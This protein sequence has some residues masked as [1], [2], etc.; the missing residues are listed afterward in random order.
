MKALLNLLT[1]LAAWLNLTT[2]CGLTARR[3]AT[4]GLLQLGQTLAGN[5]L[6]GG[7]VAGNVVTGLG[8]ALVRN[9]QGRLLD[10]IGSINVGSLTSGTSSVISGSGSSVAG[11][12]GNPGLLIGQGLHNAGQAFAGGLVIA[13]SNTASSTRF[14]GSIRDNSA[15]N[16]GVSVSQHGGL[17]GGLPSGLPIGGVLPGGTLTV[18]SVPGSGGGPGPLAEGARPASGLLPGSLGLLPTGGLPGSVSSHRSVSSSSISTSAVNTIGTLGQAPQQTNQP[19]GTGPLGPGSVPINSAAGSVAQLAA[20]TTGNFLGVTANLNGGHSGSEAPNGVSGL[21]PTGS[22]PAGRATVSGLIN[23]VDSLGGTGGGPSSVGVPV[24]SNPGTGTNAGPGLGQPLQQRG[25]TLGRL[26]VGAGVATINAATA[27]AVQIAHNSGRS[28]LG[29]VPSPNG[30]GPS[31]GAPTGGIGPA[32][33]GAGTGTIPVQGLGQTLPQNSQTLG[34]VPTGAGTATIHSALSSATQITRTSMGNIQGISSTL[35]NAG[36]GVGNPTGGGR[37]DSNGAGLGIG[38]AN[39]VGLVGA[40]GGLTSG[41][42]DGGVSS[43]GAV[44]NSINSASGINQG[45]VPGQ[46]GL[47]TSQQLGGATLVSGSTTQHLTTSMTTHEAGNTAGN[48][49]NPGQAPRHGTQPVSQ[50]PSGGSFVS[51]S[52]SSRSESRWGAQY[53]ANSQGNTGNGLPGLSGGSPG[54]QYPSGNSAPGT[55]GSGAERRLLAAIV[56]ASNGRGSMSGP[57]T[58]PQGVLQGIS[59]SSTTVSG[60][61]AAIS[62]IAQHVPQQERKKMHPAA[63]AGIALGALSGALSIGVIGAGIAGALQSGALG[64]GRRMG[65]CPGGGCRSGCGRKRR[66]VSQSRVPAEVLNNIPMDFDRLY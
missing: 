27:S 5:S 22:V 8:A 53:V 20:Q 14:G 64:G 56:A 32:L 35:N 38:V 66:S 48:G 63:A 37:P 1:V 29:V 54:V 21:S 11:S 60:S 41:G 12:G 31:V 55:P 23:A 61:H 36:T 19:L 45:Q 46:G 15:R 58:S 65:G 44:S 42:L 62:G 6:G 40:L 39:G 57:G 59:S 50:G 17:P 49:L 34:G 47:P 25:Q 52:S 9:A 10:R 16:V 33:N 4:A 18:S 51:V 30:I 24:L 43:S 2:G 3:H 7:G 28:F 13:T 26:S